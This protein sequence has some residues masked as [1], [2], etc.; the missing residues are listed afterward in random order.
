VPFALWSYRRF[1][2]VWMMFV[3]LTANLCAIVA[4]G[5]LMPIEH[6]TV[7]DAVGVERA[8]EYTPG[9]WIAGSK[10]V[11]VKRGDGQAVALGDSIVV[12]A[13]SGGLV[14]SPGDIVVWAGLLLMAAEGAVA[15]QR[16]PRGQPQ[17]AGGQPPVTAE[18]GATT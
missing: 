4:N 13:G 2:G 18:G 11:L 1:A 16:R 6:A 10:D 17:P 9:E 12:R 3:G 5:G 8:V 7:V 14:V 15:W